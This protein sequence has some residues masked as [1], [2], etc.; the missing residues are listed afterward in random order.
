MINFDIINVPRKCCK[1]I[2]KETLVVHFLMHN[3]SI[4][5]NFGELKNG[6]KHKLSYALRA[7]L[8]IV[9]HT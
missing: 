2:K 9:I 5:S 6:T 7:R 8:T 3:A 4:D 1:L